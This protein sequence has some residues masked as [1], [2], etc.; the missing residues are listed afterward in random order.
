MDVPPIE[1]G[2]QVLAAV[3]LT[4]PRVMAIFAMIPLLSRQTLPG[5]LRTGVCASV[6]ALVFPSVYDQMQAAQIGTMMGVAFCAKEVVL[7]TAIGFVV[8]I[9]LWA[10][11]AMG[12]FADNQRGASISQ[13][14]NPMTGHD[15]SPLGEL[16]SQAAITYLAASG[17]LLLLLGAIYRSYEL[18]PVF[19]FLPPLDA[20]APRI[21]LGQ[22]D[23][24]TLLAVLLG[25]PVL[26]S[27]L[28]SELGL[29]LVSRFAPQ[30]QV[31]FLAM[32]IKSGIA[33]FVF[34]IYAVTIFDQGGLLIL[35]MQ[36]ALRTVGS[37][38]DE[39]AR[40]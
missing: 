18:W 9:P 21:L 8:A 26:I 35:D 25:A 38:F 23:R 12:S 39:G 15:S 16:F 1:A 13:T 7:G 4:L 29:A 33:M 14:I 17:G 3:S 5:L 40:R 30:L 37:L 11:D 34:A 32:P 20:H 24:L 2:M 36:G 28:L 27:M 31:F 19:Q 10:F 22:L 6:G